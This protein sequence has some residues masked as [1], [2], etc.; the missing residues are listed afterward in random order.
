MDDEST[1]NR[2]CY[3]QIS[4]EQDEEAE[5]MDQTCSRLMQ[6]LCLC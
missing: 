6:T 3:K 1:Q 4:E 2:D 5:E